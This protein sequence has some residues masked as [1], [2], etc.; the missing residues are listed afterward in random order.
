[1][2]FDS[3]SLASG[4]FGADVVPQDL[5]SGSTATKIRRTASITHGVGVSV[6]LDDGLEQ[7]NH[8]MDLWRDV[9]GEAGGEK[10]VEA[11][12][13]FLP[14]GD[15]VWVFKSS[16][17]K[18][19]KENS[20]GEWRQWYEYKLTLKR[21]ETD[22]DGEQELKK[23]PT[24]CSI[25]IQ[26][27][28]EGLT[29][30]DGNDFSIPYGEGTRLRIR[31]TYVERSGQV[32]DRL[33]TCLSDALKRLGGDPD[34]VDVGDM[35]ADSARIFKLET[36]VRFDIDEKHPVKLCLDKSENLIDVG[37]GAEVKTWKRRDKAGWMEA[38]ITS[39]RWDRL[40]FDPLEVD[41]IEDGEE[42][43]KRL[44]RELKCYQ[45][46]NWEDRSRDDPLHHPKLEASLGGESTAHL[47]EWDST[48]K[49]LRRL[50]L[51]HLEWAGVDDGDLVADDYFKPS[52][53]PTV[54]VAHPQ[55]RREDLRRFY[56]RFEPVVWSAAMKY[57]TDAQ[58]DILSVICEN[59]GATYDQL[60]SATGYSRSNV[61]YHVGELK[62]LGLLVTVGNPAIIAFDA[63]YLYEKVSELI[64][65]KIAPHFDEETISARRLG[66]E[67][68]AREREEARENGEANG[69]GSSSGDGD[70]DQEERADDQE[71]ADGER[72]EFVYLS[73]WEGN[74]LDL[75]HEL[76]SPDHRRDEEDVRIREFGPPR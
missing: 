59:Y 26:P 61:E 69:C 51:S 7:Y 71:D 75:E 33:F 62:D 40:G 50:V 14:D 10:I 9:I 53:Q 44:S 43:T 54:E 34:L 12:P 47:S 48:L 63:D 21:R 52:T 37:G 11:D 22:E 41:A 24:S 5:E 20:A 16:G 4:E 30:K 19:G 8:S 68:R 73:E 15:Y 18:A 1:M 46:T 55:G 70:G 76:E 72:G 60:V 3:E 27:Q 2:S 49:S 6:V 42:T 35:K 39:D 29:Y 45:A 74:L 36:H 67:E 57:Q 64:D 66:R 65:S 58:Y 25:D 28:A 23:P 31:T 32:I 38:R 13:D 56:S 17:W